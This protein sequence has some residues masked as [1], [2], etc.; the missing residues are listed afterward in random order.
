VTICDGLTQ[1][2]KVVGH[3]LHPT[4]VV[5][6]AE[7]ALFEGVKPGVELQNMRLV[8]VEELSLDHEPCLACSLRQ[9]PNDLVEFG[10][11]GV[12]DPC[13]HDVVQSSPIDGW[14]GDVGEDVVVEGVAMKREKHEV[15]PPLVVG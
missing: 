9:I 12:E 2:T 4:T 14:I 10:G 13:H 7:V 15:T 5:V 3:A 11:E 1:V 8:V 6:N